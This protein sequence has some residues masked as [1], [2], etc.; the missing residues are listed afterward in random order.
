MI[1]IDKIPSNKQYIH[2]RVERPENC[3]INNWDRI[4]IEFIGIE[5]NITNA[6]YVNGLKES[7]EV[8]IRNIP[9]PKMSLSFNLIPIGEFNI[10]A[11]FIDNFRMQT[12]FEKKLISEH[13]ANYNGQYFFD[14]PCKKAPK[15]LIV[16]FPGMGNNIDPDSQYS[17]MTMKT[18]PFGD[19]IYRLHLV[20]LFWAN[21]SCLLFNDNKTSNIDNIIELIDTVLSN[22]NLS[23]S[24]CHIITA[25]K[26]CF[27]AYEVMKSRDFK[28][29][30]FAPI[31]NVERF[32]ESS[33]VMRFISRELLNNG[34]RFY[35]P[36]FKD[37]AS[38][39]TSIKDPGID[40]GLVSNCIS[41]I[42]E[43]LLHAQ[44]TKRFINEYLYSES[45]TTQ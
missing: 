23:H 13:L 8:L 33:P 42:D 43:S 31:T 19:D 22:N 25:S 9:I 3:K 28:Y 36:T 38:V 11:T 14:F 18:L 5:K 26:G 24:D 17:I 32:N 7:N 6:Y 44:I 39:Y 4:C 29:A 35:K 2:I 15:K 27:A 41:T 30:F 10:T 12:N 16:T 40:L 1:H 45:L 21:G 37:N 20:D 34:Y